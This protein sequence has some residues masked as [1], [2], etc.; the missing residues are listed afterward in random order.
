MNKMIKFFIITVI[1]FKLVPNSYSAENYQN[2]ILKYVNQERK[3]KKL[4]PLIMNEKLNKIA[5]KKAADMAKEEKLSHDSKNFGITFNLIKN[6]NI[7]YKSAAENIAKWHDTP[8]FVMERWMQ[9]KG[10]RDNIL[11]KNY[12]EIGIGKAADKNG[13]NY[14]VQIF[15]EKKK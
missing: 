1:I 14:W 15:I 2:E 6:E 4:A 11:N 13:K 7:K 12:N 3:T 5:I 10:H 8:E 9:S